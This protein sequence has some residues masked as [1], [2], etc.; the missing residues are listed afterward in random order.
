MGM[1]DHVVVEEGVD[2]PEFPDD[3]SEYTWQTKDFDTLNFTTYK[4]TDDGR[5]LQEEFHYEEVPKEERPYPDADP[6]EEPLK[7]MAGRMKKVNDGWTERQ[8]HGIVNFYHAIP[9][10]DDPIDGDRM[11]WE[12]DAKFTDG[13]LEN[14]NLTDKHEL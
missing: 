10:D 7:A 8:Y 1:F 5:L 6:D 11:W 13:Q 4:I 2:L 14:I 9:I 12:Y 3:A